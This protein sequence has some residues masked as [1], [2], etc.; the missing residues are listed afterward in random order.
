MG[1]WL[2]SAVGGKVGGMGGRMDGWLGDRAGG[3]VGGRF[4]VSE[5]GVACV[6]KHLLACR[7]VVVLV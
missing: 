4:S 3:R 1:Q 7:Y 5:A 6:R 2:S